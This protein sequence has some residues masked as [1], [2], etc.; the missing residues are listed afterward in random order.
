MN[1]QAL[2]TK[3]NHLCDSVQYSVK[4]IRNSS[5]IIL[6]MWILYLILVILFYVSDPCD[7]VH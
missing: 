5:F 2:N 3:L 4:V 6:H 7:H 1:P